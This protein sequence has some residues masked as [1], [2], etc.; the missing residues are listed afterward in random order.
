MVDGFY[1]MLALFSTKL[2]KKSEQEAAEEAEIRQNTIPSSVLGFA[3][4]G[5]PL[6]SLR[7]PVQ[8]FVR[9]AVGQAKTLLETGG[10]K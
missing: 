10:Q 4:I 3:S 9:N 5:D 7:P 2:R 1:M 6:F 8:N